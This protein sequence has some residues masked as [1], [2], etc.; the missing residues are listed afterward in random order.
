MPTPDTIAEPPALV[1]EEDIVVRRLMHSGAPF[2]D[3]AVLS[4][5]LEDA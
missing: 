3:I 4:G 2:W 5:R 1:V